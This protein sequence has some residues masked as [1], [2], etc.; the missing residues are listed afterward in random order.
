MSVFAGCNHCKLKT[1]HADA[2]RDGKVVT[3]RPVVGWIAVFVGE[4]HKP[5]EPPIDF[6]RL[7]PVAMFM[8]LGTRCDC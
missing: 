2:E 4:P 6:F 7:E 1:I 5:G 8:A 3:L